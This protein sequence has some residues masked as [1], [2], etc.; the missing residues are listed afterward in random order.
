MQPKHFTAANALFFSF[1]FPC[2]VIIKMTPCTCN[3]P[4]PTKATKRGGGAEVKIYQE[5]KTAIKNNW[6]L[7]ATASN[8]KSTAVQVWGIWVSIVIGSVWKRR[9]NT[10]CFPFHF[11]LQRQMPWL[12]PAKYTP[13][14]LQILLLDGW[15]IMQ[16][17]QTVWLSCAYW[18]L[19]KLH[20]TQLSL[21]DR[22]ICWGYSCF[23]SWIGV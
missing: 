17:V 5:N 8:T 2:R 13:T 10:S 19:W 1:S 6:R 21:F 3:L 7:L 20:C 14:W 16:V 15:K 4:E 18:A 9:K 23:R 22:M 11:A 12:F